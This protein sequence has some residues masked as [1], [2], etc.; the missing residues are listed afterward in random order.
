[1]PPADQLDAHHK[2]LTLNLDPTI[3]GSFA[4]IGAGQEVARWFLRVGGASG[5]VAKAISAYDKEV[6]D[7]LY[8]PGTRYVSRERLEAMLDR[9]WD[10]LQTQLRE[11]R[12][13]TSRFFTFAD[14]VSARNYAG[15][16]ESHGWMGVRFLTEPGGEPNDVLLHVNMMDPSNP[17]QQ[18]VLGTLGVNLVYGAY[19]Q[20]ESR[21]VFLRGLSEGIAA[22]RIEIDL[23]DLRGPAFEAWDRRALLVEIVRR[24]LAEAVVFPRDGRALPP[25]EVLHKKPVVLAPGTFETVEPIHGRI[26]AATLEELR[27]EASAVS[28]APIG[29]FALT[30]D[31]PSEGEK[32]PDVPYLLR[33]VDALRPLGEAV[34]LSR[35]RELY[36][37]SAFVNRFTTA[38][39]R[40]AVGLPTLIRVFQ[41]AHYHPLQGR[42]L[43]GIS[44]LFAQNVRVYAYP[45]TISALEERL[46]ALSANG[47]ELPDTG[48]WVTADRLRPAPPLS[49]LYAYLIA[50]GF[51]VPMQPSA[52]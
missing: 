33:H 2:A 24:G 31:A 47:W 40:F 46:R 8:G 35:R 52:S 30:A 10:Q 22:R 20:R 39:V 32:P 43:E 11:S 42:I 9:E 13:S 50:T 48:G 12:G 37:L 27:A 14:T 26:L 18:E 36:Q 19:H 15:T 29:L 7:D 49:H 6:S 28:E 16:N 38:A 41:D 5:T 17:L 25:T 21:D 51:I 4:E 45:A 3:F 23:I 1:M 34:L 44:R